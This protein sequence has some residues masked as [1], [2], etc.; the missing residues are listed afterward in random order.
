MA[1]IYLVFDFG[2]DEEKAQQALQKLGVWKQA[3]RLDKKMQY[4]VARADENGA[5]GEASSEAT[6]EATGKSGKSKSA[7][8]GAKK[9]E[10]AKAGS[11]STSTESVRLLVRLAFSS[12]EK[13]TGQRWLERIPSEEPF[14]SAA[15]KVV[16]QSDAAFA[17]VD[18]EFANLA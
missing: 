13:L 12:H 11:G 2:S 17:Q 8:K 9:G 7:A 1:H 15:P 3:G 6:A 10:E 4:K 14:Q 16:K 18:E 5:A